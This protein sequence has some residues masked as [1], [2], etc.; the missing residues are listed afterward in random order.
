MQRGFLR[1]LDLQDDEAFMQY[2]FTPPSLRRAIGL[3]GFLHKRV[4][5]IYHPGLVKALPYLSGASGERKYHTKMLERSNNEVSRQR[6]LYERSLYKYIHIYNV[7]PQALIDSETVKT[8]QSRLTKLIQIRIESSG[9]NWRNSFQSV[10][11]T[12]EW[13]HPTPTVLTLD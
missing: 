10:V 11:D 1:E 13:F 9:T 5:G 8:F 4:L 3:L 2:N 6:C 12:V 7:L